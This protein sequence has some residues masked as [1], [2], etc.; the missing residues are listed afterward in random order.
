MT[1]TF[2]LEK[3][4]LNVR[5]KNSAYLEFK[6]TYNERLAFDFNLL[7]FFGVGENKVSELLA[8]FL[9]PKG[10]HGQST[11]FLESFLRMVLNSDFVDSLD[12]SISSI[13]CEHC[14]PTK[15]RLDILIRLDKHL[16]G[17]ENKIWA[18]DQHRQLLDYSDYLNRESKGNYT[19]IYLNPYGS[20][21]THSSIEPEISKSLQEKS[22]LQIRSYKNDIIPLLEHWEALCKADNVSFFI[23]QLQEHLKTK[24]LGNNNLSMNSSIKELINSY[25][26]EVET[27][28]S[29]YQSL[30][31]ELLKRFDK[32][33]NM[34]A[35][36]NFDFPQNLKVEKS[37][38]F[39][40]E[41]MR[42]FKFGIS[43]Q[44]NKIW[45]QFV[46]NKLD[47]KFGYYFQNGSDISRNAV[48]ENYPLKESTL[49]KDWNNDQIIEEYL[50]Q[51]SIA[52]KLLN[53]Y[54]AINN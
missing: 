54:V 33:S 12:L 9:N 7:N 16:I 34:I 11:K 26:N 1:E 20:L 21:P 14:L 52:C 36:K 47:Y 45:I 28:I 48:N 24:F 49:P 2:E 8:F 29:A 46:K 18:G 13:E 3:L 37:K 35:A 50:N 17:I 53:D 27:L 39:M 22:I 10:V 42:V 15:R 4:L 43:N 51:L 40:Y 44:N 31:S 25:P 5:S 30:D 32:I 6:K 19:L 23:R 38:P 41:G